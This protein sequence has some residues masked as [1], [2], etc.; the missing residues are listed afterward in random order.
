MSKYQ[1]TVQTVE[2]TQKTIIVEAESLDEAE[3]IG[4]IE[5][6]D[7]DDGWMNVQETDPIV[8]NITDQVKGS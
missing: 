6:F 4:L 2:V 5:V 1:I 7:T 8:I 3:G